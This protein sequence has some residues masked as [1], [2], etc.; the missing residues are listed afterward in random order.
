[1][2]LA[3]LQASQQSVETD[4]IRGPTNSVSCMDVMSCEIAESFLRLSDQLTEDSGDMLYNASEK[5]TIGHLLVDKDFD[6]SLYINICFR[7]PTK[8]ISTY[9]L[10]D[11]GCEISVIDAAFVD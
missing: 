5:I 1:M 8:E 3:Y 9:A 7:T 2:Q 10:V 11:S 6:K 4:F